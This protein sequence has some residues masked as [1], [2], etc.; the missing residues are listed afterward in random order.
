[1]DALFILHA[2]CLETHPNVRASSSVVGETGF[3]IALRSSCQQAYI[4]LVVD[5]SQ[6][7]GNIRVE[8]KMVKNPE[9]SY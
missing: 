7:T 8:L 1:M 5:V 9:V 2:V 6:S 3:R 4:K